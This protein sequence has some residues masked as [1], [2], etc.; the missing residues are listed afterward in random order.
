MVRYLIALALVLSPMSVLADITGQPRVIDDDTL[1]FDG[2]A[3]Q[4]MHRQAQHVPERPREVRPRS[5]FAL[6]LQ[7]L[8]ETR[9]SWSRGLALAQCRTRVLRTLSK[10]F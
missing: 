7:S 8:R 5:S 3:P 10:D 6:A 1:E 2:R 4:V 9:L